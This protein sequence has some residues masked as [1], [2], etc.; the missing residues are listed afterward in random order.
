MTDLARWGILSTAHINRRLIPVIQESSRAELVG[1]ASRSLPVAEEYARKWSIGKAYGSYDEML[2]D[3]EIDVIY[4]SLPNH[5]HAE[6]SIR[7][8]R[9]GKH[10]LCEKPLCLTLE[11]LERIREVS[12]ETGK[13]TT[14]A[15]MYL[16]HPQMQQIRDMIESGSIGR[17][18]A[19]TGTFSAT[20]ERPGDN[21]RFDAA[22]GGGALWDVGVYPVSLFQHITGHQPVRVTG[23][24]AG[25]PVDMHFWGMLEY[26]DA[27]VG[28]FYA[29]FRAQFS[30][31]ARF[32]GTEGILEV[33]HPFVNTDACRA[34]L[35]S[36]ESMEEISLPRASLYAGEVEDMN[37][38]V[39]DGKEPRISLDDSFGHLRTVLR[40]VESANHTG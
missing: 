14:E 27:V 6:W 1:V 19:M 22:K 26:P 31:L 10:V 29:S 21:Y 5:L 8:M 39:L 11:E 28:Q 35:Y 40:L 16:H 34:R 25:S 3:P 17:L 13:V 37:S 32:T 38:V 33:T 18:T 20:I 4:N 30:T 9:A 15:F 36:G 12:S 23:R 24:N 2:A 7:A